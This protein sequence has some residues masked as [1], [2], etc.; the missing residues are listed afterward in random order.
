MSDYAS[1]ST[2]AVLS[3]LSDRNWGDLDGIY[4]LL[5]H[6][7]GQVVF[8]NQLVRAMESFSP[9]I[10]WQVK[11][12]ALW[13]DTECGDINRGT[14]A[15]LREEAIRRFGETQR[16]R[17]SGRHVDFTDPVGDLEALDKPVVVIVIETK[18]KP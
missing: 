13:L 3:V 4:K 6:M 12:L 16:L 8:T 7:S 15:A 5:R 17:P 10:R 9:D 2:E 18:E 14:V 1:F 11:E